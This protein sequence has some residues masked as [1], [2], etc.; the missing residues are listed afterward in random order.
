VHTGLGLADKFVD[1]NQQWRIAGEPAPPVDKPCQF[2]QRL[3]AV[4]S[5]RL[6]R[7]ASDRFCVCL[8]DNGLERIVDHCLCV[9]HVELTH[10][11][12]RVHPISIG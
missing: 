9:P 8:I 11:R 7:R 5:L 3:K 1:R 10:L 4:A 2:R 6:G 12:K